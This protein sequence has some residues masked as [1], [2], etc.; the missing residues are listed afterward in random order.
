MNTAK[1]R[2]NQPLQFII[3]T[4]QSMRKKHVSRYTVGV[5]EDSM[6]YVRAKRRTRPIWC[7]DSAIQ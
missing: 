6:N 3:T 2:T 1:C 4:G 5:D 7:T